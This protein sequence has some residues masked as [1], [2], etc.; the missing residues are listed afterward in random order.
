M[1]CQVS[2]L[3][4]KKEETEVKDIQSKYKVTAG[5]PHWILRGPVKDLALVEIIGNLDNLIL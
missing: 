4:Y 2:H 1:I 5:S 3:L